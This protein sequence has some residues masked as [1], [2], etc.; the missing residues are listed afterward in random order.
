M[1]VNFIGRM[2]LR[3]LVW[4]SQIGE[5]QMA[6]VIRNAG[7]LLVFG[8]GEHLVDQREKPAYSVEEAAG[9]LG[10]PVNTLYAWTLG[11]R[12]PNSQ[13]EY[14]PSVLEFVDRRTQRLSFFDLVE[15]H[16]LRAAVDKEIPLKQIKRGLAYVREAYPQYQRPLLKLDFRTDGK[17]LLV[18]GML[19]S[20]EK[21]REALVNASRH[22]QLEI[23]GVIEEYLEL[24]GWDLD[25][26]P[27]TIFPK[28]GQRLVS[29]SSGIV[30]GRPAIEGTRIPTALIAQRFRAGETQNELAVDYKLPMEAI[31][32]AIKYEK[33]A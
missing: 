4:A 29:I 15:A 33:A 2:A 16:I 13:C 18:G 21:D 1:A 19:G 23:T 30:S 31:E 17:Y 6:S 24:I 32:A 11:R 27:D 3:M 7:R 14:Y 22:G 10:I 20:K 9:Y 26:N 25:G 8:G 12:K 5:Y 28:T